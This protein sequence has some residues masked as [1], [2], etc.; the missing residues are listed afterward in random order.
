MSAI[1]FFATDSVRE[2]QKCNNE[3]RWESA[4]KLKLMDGLSKKIIALVGGKWVCAARAGRR[5]AGVGGGGGSGSAE[6]VMGSDSGLSRRSGCPELCEAAAPR[7]QNRAGC[8][9]RKVP[10]IQ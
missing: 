4:L 5:S 1:I 2:A 9:S 6:R 7:W 10:L 8:Q 3:Y